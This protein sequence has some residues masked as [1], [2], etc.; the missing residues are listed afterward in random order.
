MEIINKIILKR[1][2]N[3]YILNSSFIPLKQFKL[4][5]FLQ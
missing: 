3:Y 2:L 1:S 5:Y 4:L